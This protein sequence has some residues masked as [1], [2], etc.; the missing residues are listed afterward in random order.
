VDLGND[1]KLGMVLIPAG[2]FTMGDDNEK[3]AHKVTIT[4][5][6]YLGKYEVTQEQWEAVMGNNPSKF[7]GPKNPV[8][9]VSWD[10]CQQFLVKLNTKASGQGGKFVLPTEAQWEYACRAGSTSKFCFGD[11]EKQLGEYAWYNE[12]S[13]G[14]THPVGE[15]KPNNFGL[16]DMHG[17]VWEWCQDW[18][19]K[20]DADAV[21]DPSGPAMGANRVH[22]GGCW[23]F[24]GGSCQSA[25]RGLDATG[26]RR[27]YRGLRVSRTCADTA[28]FRVEDTNDSTRAQRVAARE[29]L[30]AAMK[31]A[32]SILEEKEKATACID[33]SDAQRRAGDVSGARK[34]LEKAR[35]V[36]AQ[37]DNE[38]DRASV[39]S[40]IAAK[41]AEARDIAGA[42]AT[43]AKI[44]E[45]SDKTEAYV[46]IAIAQATAGDFAGAKATAARI[47]DTYKKSYVYFRVASSQAKAGDIAEATATA[48]QISSQGSK[49]LAYSSIVHHQLAAGD[50]AGAKATAARISQGDS[51]KVYIAIAD[52]QAKDGD[53]AGARDSLETATA[54]AT[55]FREKTGFLSERR[56]IDAC[57]RMYRGIIEGQIKIGYFEEAKATAAQVSEDSSYSRSS[58]YVGIAVAQAKAGD[59]AGAKATVAQI[60]KEGYRDGAYREIAAAQAEAKDFAGAKATVAHFSDERAKAEPYREIAIAQAKAGDF[61]GAKATA[62]K[63]SSN[64]EKLASTYREIAFAQAESGDFEGAKTTAEATSRKEN[65]EDLASA[66][67]GIAVAQA[68]AGDVAGAKATVAQI[69]KE[70]YRD[71]AYREIAVAQAKAGDIPGAKAVASQISDTNDKVDA[72]VKIALAQINAGDVT[73][74]CKNPETAKAAALQI[75]DDSVKQQVYREIAAAQIEARDPAGANATLET[76][77][78][79]ATQTEA[80]DFARAKAAAAQISNEE[81]KTNAY[82]ELAVRLA[83]AGDVAGVIALISGLTVDPRKRCDH[84]AA[85]LAKLDMADDTQVSGSPV[86]VK[87]N[88]RNVSV[89]PEGKLFQGIGTSLAMQG[90]DVLIA[91]ILPGSPAGDH[92]RLAI[93]DRIIGV[94]QGE[95]GRIMPVAD[96]TLPAVVS[97]VHGASGTIVR[98][99]VLPKGKS[100]PETYEFKRVALS[101]T[102]SVA[103]YEKGSTF[104]ARNELDNALAQFEEAIRLDHNYAPAFRGRGSVYYRQGKF[105]LAISDYTEAIRLN[106]DNALAYHNRGV[107]YAKKQ[108]F[109][110]SIADFTE[111]IRLSP[112]VAKAYFDRGVIFGNRGD[113][114]KA[115]ADYTKAIE[116]NPEFADA[117]NNRGNV[118]IKEG[119]LSRALADHKAAVQY[120]P[121]NTITFENRRAFLTRLQQKRTESVDAMARGAED[122]GLVKEAESL[123]EPSKQ[124]AAD[125]V[126][127]GFSRQEWQEVKELVKSK[128][129]GDADAF[130]DVLLVM[131]GA[132][133]DVGIPNPSVRQLFNGIQALTYG[134]GQKSPAEIATSLRTSINLA[135]KAGIPVMVKEDAEKLDQDRPDLFSH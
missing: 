45:E 125:S 28:V 128:A 133:A 23:C 106:P 3:P 91:G 109:D 22:R 111:G 49:D 69:R 61:A 63:T 26:A 102:P 33:I 59:V 85:T 14:K 122:H 39:Y 107:V 21:D 134:I 64:T 7:K 42:E 53:K 9:Q 70:G 74:A 11:E 29:L 78:A 103:A 108:E 27:Y 93:G 40:K 20:Y 43:T 84:F 56:R 124:L 89:T 98:L 48:V 30:G 12:N 81:D 71:G 17:N 8:E 92:P 114:D 19:V 2:S 67:R 35:T 72:Y 68:K 31:E 52:A 110:K 113:R 6:F 60:R 10:D 90:S 87:T 79:T 131:K 129:W 126:P 99:R 119:D 5:P 112:I 24:V 130:R 34:T 95:A 123:K 135:K 97:L 116:L 118:Y 51:T 117:Y 75:R 58:A 100:K 73:G 37:V 105:E 50:L 54:A 121:K 104:L 46:A 1:V 132:F 25:C 86:D 77:K 57:D 101:F 94:G 82:R 88:S 18:Y 44:T 76:T 83:K 115:V 96:M 13:G 120:T 38:Q 41:Q 4:K 16:Y 62:E 36:A 66:Y 80:K 55:S 127:G 47:H 32:Q 65:D 15:K